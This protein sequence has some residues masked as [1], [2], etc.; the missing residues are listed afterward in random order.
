MK[1]KIKKEE[2]TKDDILDLADAQ[3][4]KLGFLLATCPLDEDTKVALVGII[5]KLSP[6]QIEVVTDFFEEGLLAAQNQP[7]ND[8]LKE[9][10][11]KI[12]K[13]YDTRQWAVDEKTIANIDNLE[14]SIKE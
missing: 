6:E 7:L 5:E 4:R 14:K 12:N 13:E 11:E 3:G 8:W 9:K 10:M 1:D 2:L